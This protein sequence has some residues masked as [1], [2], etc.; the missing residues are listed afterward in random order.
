MLFVKRRCWVRS[1]LS[2]FLVTQFSLDR[3]PTAE[4]HRPV[5]SLN[6][7]MRCLLSVHGSASTQWVIRPSQSVHATQSTKPSAQRLLIGRAGRVTPIKASLFLAD[8]LFDYPIIRRVLL[9][10]WAVVSA[11]FQAANSSSPSSSG[12]TRPVLIRHKSTASCLASATAA[13]FF[14]VLPLPL[15]IFF[16]RRSR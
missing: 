8:Y 16:Q 1:L 13:F 14:I 4:R 9:S 10:V 12:W 15:K 6:A 5:V 7:A 3:C 11:P 2:L